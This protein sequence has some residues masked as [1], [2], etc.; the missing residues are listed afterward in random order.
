MRIYIADK[1]VEQFVKETKILGLY[2]GWHL[3]IEWILTFHGSFSAKKIHFN[4]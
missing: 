1:I 2:L 4:D 3:A